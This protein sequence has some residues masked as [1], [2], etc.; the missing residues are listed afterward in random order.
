[1]NVPEHLNAR[2]SELIAWQFEAA[3][4]EREFW[5]MRVEHEK[6]EHELRCQK[7]RCNEAGVMIQ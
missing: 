3:K 6:L 7:A 4:A 1:M 2:V 5:E